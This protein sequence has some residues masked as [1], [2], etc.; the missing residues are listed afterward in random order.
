M[1]LGQQDHI[2]NVICLKIHT[3]PL[4]VNRSRTCYPN[5]III[6]AVMKL[7]F[8]RKII[9]YLSHFRFVM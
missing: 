7:G 9:D 2:Y 4:F 6:M 3:N 8:H 1:G 5:F